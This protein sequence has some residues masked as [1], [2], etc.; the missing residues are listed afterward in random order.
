MT[1]HG[2]S[3]RTPARR[4]RR[5]GWA[6]SAS[7]DR[8]VA[9]KAWPALARRRPAAVRDGAKRRVS[10]RRA[11]ADV[12]RRKRWPRQGSVGIAASSDPARGR[13]ITTPP[14]RGRPGDFE[15]CRLPSWAPFRRPGAAGR[16]Y[17]A[18]PRSGREATVSTLAEAGV[19]PSTSTT[20]CGSR[21]SRDRSSSTCP[22][23]RLGPPSSGSSSR[24]RARNSPTAATAHRRRARCTDGRHLVVA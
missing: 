5:G 1:R 11:R 18:A 2:S 16:R 3:R 10:R 9:W 7:R 23:A 4:T 12:A 8:V 15:K 20:L 24:A 6:V 21:I 13:A 22:V 14:C 19:R 17:P